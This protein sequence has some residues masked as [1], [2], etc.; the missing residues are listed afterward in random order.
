MILKSMHRMNTKVPFSVILFLT[1]KFDF[2]NF[3]AEML[4]NFNSNSGT[5][6]LTLARNKENDSN[7]SFKTILL[8]VVFIN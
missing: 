3:L 4:S 8:S 2:H 5:E 7:K 1:S 6:L